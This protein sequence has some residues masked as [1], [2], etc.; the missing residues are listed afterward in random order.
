VTEL[1]TRIGREARKRRSPSSARALP[2]AR[3][4]GILYAILLALKW[5]WELLLEGS[6]FIVGKLAPFKA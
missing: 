5:I 1:W 3:A 6:M 2:G 4:S